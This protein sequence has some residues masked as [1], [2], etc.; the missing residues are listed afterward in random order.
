ML[1]HVEPTDVARLRHGFD[2]RVVDLGDFVESRAVDEEEAGVIDEEVQLAVVFFLHE[3]GDA[4]CVG[5]VAVVAVEGGD[6]EVV[7]G[8]RDF[9][10]F[11]LGLLTRALGAGCE[12]EAC[13]AGLGEAFGDSG[14]DAATG[15]CDDS[16][17]RLWESD[18]GGV[19][20]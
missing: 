20:D 5:F 14:T 9:A 4:R 16:D 19:E 12:D 7:G 6:L 13:G 15:A 1:D 3:F 11:F 2:V 18:L 8:R 10:A 17:E